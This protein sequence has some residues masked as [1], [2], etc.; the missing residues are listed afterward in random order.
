VE[1][2]ATLF[3]AVTVFAVGFIPVNWV[4]W[5]DLVLNSQSFS[6]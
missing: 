5:G 4:K 3:G 2:A 1:A 6:F